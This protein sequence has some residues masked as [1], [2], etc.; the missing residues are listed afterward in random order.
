MARQYGVY[1]AQDGTSE[2]AL[3]VIDA[4]GVIRW[5]YVSPVG[6]NPGADGILKALEALTARCPHEPPRIRGAAHRARIG[7]RSRHRAGHAPVTLVEYGDYQCP[8]CGGAYPIVQEVQKRLRRQVA[9]RVPQFPARP[10]PSAR[11]ARGGGGRG[12]GGPGEVLGDARL[13]LRAPDTL[14][15]DDLLSTPRELG[16]DADA[17]RATWRTHTLAPRVRDDFSA[18]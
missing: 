8:Y 11:G 16:L 7:A 15:D 3:F 6:V 1:R 2:R 9:L 4:E 13:A 12:G 10:D 14:E 5:S 18:G 17:S